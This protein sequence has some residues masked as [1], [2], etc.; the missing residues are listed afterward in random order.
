M[1]LLITESPKAGIPVFLSCFVNAI[2]VPA[3]PL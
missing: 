2:P 1:Y 3:S